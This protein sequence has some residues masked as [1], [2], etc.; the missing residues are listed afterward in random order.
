MIKVKLPKLSKYG[1]STNEKKEF[2]CPYCGKEDFYWTVFP[3]RCIRCGKMLPKMVS[4]I[5][6]ADKRAAW[7]MFGSVGEG[8]KP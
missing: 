6:N 8:I 2:E 7:H 5:E 3:S 1:Y 4:I